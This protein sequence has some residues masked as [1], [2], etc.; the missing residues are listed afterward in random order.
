[1]KESKIS[2]NI[3]GIALDFM[4]E[5]NEEFMLNV[6]AFMFVFILMVLR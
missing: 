4:V 2:S 6:H 1:M 3:L 5:Q